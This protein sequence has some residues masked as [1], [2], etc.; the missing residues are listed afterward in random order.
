MGLS[1]WDGSVRGHLLRWFL[2]RKTLTWRD[3]H[4]GTGGIWASPL[5]SYTTEQLAAA[6]AQGCQVVVEI[7]AQRP[8][9]TSP[10]V[11]QPNL[12]SYLNFYYNQRVISH[13]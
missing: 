1:T 12:L 8:P 13:H 5:T 3:V 7:S 9:K 10:K 11:A 4:K 6:A 2:H